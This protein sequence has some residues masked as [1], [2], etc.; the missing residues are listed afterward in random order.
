MRQ[1]PYGI[2]G[3]GRVAR[4]FCHHL[5]LLHIP[6]LQW[7]RRA[8]PGAN[9]L[10]NLIQCQ[11]ILLLIKDDAIESFIDQHPILKTTQ[12]IHFSGCLVTANAVGI[13]P[14]FT[15]ATELYDLDVYRSIPFFMEKNNKD[16]ATL[17]PGINNPHYIINP[18]QK[19]FYHA[20]C[21]MSGNFTTLLWQK[22]FKE[23]ETNFN[24]PHQ[25][26]LPYL[27]QITNNLNQQHK[28]VLTGPLVRGDQK[29]IQ[30]NLNALNNDPFQ[31]IYQTFVEV[32]QEIKH[33][34][35]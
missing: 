11:S 10:A 14:L 9:K 35:S 33:E 1:V 5:D 22:F 16:F 12:L 15:F 13:H 4:H 28:T 34:Y 18:Q 24:I 19:A 25:A 6:Y 30:T 21:V 8:D 17:L 26:A 7:S 23:L 29:T 2:I 27:T 31:K 32:Y 3:D 20:L